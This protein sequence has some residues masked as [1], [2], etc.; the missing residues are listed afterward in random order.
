MIALEEQSPSYCGACPTNCCSPCIDLKVTRQ[1]FDRC[2]ARH[3]DKLSV[4]DLGAYLEVTSNITKDCPNFIDDRCAIYEDR[5]ME[6]RL[7]PHSVQDIDLISGGVRAYVHAGTRM[8]PHKSELM[9]PEP[10]VL[11]MVRGFLEDAYPGVPQTI[12]L[13]Q[14]PGRLKLKWLRVSKQAKRRMAAT[15]GMEIR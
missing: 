7:Y 9:A 10:Q 5:P 13:E 12:V 15:L 14:D 1:E 11:E 2:F 6:C 8:C 3:A 4:K